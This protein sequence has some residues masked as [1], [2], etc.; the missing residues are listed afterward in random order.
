MDESNVTLR[1]TNSELSILQVLWRMGSATVREVFDKL[2][3]KRETGYTTVLKTMQIMH[4]KGL[5]D[6]EESGKAHIYR[7]TKAADNSRHD[8]VGEL[9]DKAFGGSAQQLVMSALN[10][11]PA[12]AEEIAAIRQ[13]LD[14]MEGRND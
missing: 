10:S 13:L 1:P 11:K 4:E 6:R 7:P 12:T 2:A 8:L 3:G 14:E 9:M 5:L